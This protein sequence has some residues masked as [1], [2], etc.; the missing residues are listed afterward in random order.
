MYPKIKVISYSW[1]I[2]FIIKKFNYLMP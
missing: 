2:V 1:V